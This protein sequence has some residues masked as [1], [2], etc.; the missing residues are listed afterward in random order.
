MSGALDVWLRS[1]PLVCIRAA[2]SHSFIDLDIQ[3]DMHLPF[4][5]QGTSKDIPFYFT[6]FFQISLIFWH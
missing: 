4:N 1:E 6:C 2:Q 3:E 5:L